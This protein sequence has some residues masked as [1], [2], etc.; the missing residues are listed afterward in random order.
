MIA[1][2][3]TGCRC[4]EG[5]GAGGDQRDRMGGPLLA[6]VDRGVQDGNKDRVDQ[7]RAMAGNLQ[8]AGTRAVV[9]Q[10]AA[11]LGFQ[12]AFV[13]VEALGRRQMTVHGGMQGLPGVVEQRLRVI[14]HARG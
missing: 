6:G 7:Q 11:L 1:E 2:A 12:K 9:L 8:T 3:G 4:L 13:Q 5:D 14:W 10:N